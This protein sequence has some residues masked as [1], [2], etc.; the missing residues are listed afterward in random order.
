MN[1][2]IPLSP[3]MEANIRAWVAYY[4]AHPEYI[5]VPSGLWNGGQPTYQ[6]RI[7]IQD[8]TRELFEAIA[9]QFDLPVNDWTSRYG[10]LKNYETKRLSGGPDIMHS[11]RLEGAG[12]A[13]VEV[14]GSPKVTWG[15]GPAPGVM[16]PARSGVSA[17]VGS[18]FQGAA[19]EYLSWSYESEDKGS[20]EMRPQLLG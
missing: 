8:Q 14:T 7:V 2:T 18:P 13:S 6:S 12:A 15:V 4:K 10:G 19:G 5:G 1:L 11:I 16:D 9:A 3:E 20:R 17:G